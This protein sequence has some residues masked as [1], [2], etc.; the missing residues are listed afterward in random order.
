M[1]RYRKKPT[2][3]DAHQVGCTDNF[4]FLGALSCTDWLIYGFDGT[5]S[6]LDNAS[7]NSKYAQTNDNATL[8]GSDYT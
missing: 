6:T 3:V 4:G 5:L 1:A 8:T 2:I 7:F